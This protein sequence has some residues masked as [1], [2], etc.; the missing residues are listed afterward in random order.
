[1]SAT[2]QNAVARGNEKC[3]HH[4]DAGLLTG[5]C[6]QHGVTSQLSQGGHA[7]PVG[8]PMKFASTHLIAADIKAFVSFYENVT[9]KT[10]EW[11]GPGLSQ[12]AA[13]TRRISSFFKRY[14]SAYHERRQRRRLRAALCDLNDREL[15]DI[16]TT[17]GEVDYVSSNRNIDPRGIRSAE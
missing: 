13:S 5:R 3:A 6:Q 12:T 16:G 1:M 14:M 9:G 8:N 10:A 7:E 15:M 4:I 2:G 11:L 17:R